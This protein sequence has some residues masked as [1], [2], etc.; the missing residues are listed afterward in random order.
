M[1]GR[2]VAYLYTPAGN[3][4]RTSVRIRSIYGGGSRRVVSGFAAEGE[5]YRVTS[6]VVDGRYVYW[7]QEDRI[8]D[9]FFSGRGLAAKAGT[10]E[11]TAQTFPGR[12]TSIAIGS[13]TFYYVNGRGL[14]QATNPGFAPRD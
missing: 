10:L 5:S 14:H 9:E 12:V 11:F 6:P 13:G 8:R 3:P 1:R 7:L 4:S 2:R